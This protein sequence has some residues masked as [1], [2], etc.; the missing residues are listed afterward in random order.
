MAGAEVASAYVTIIPKLDES[1]DSVG[2]KMKAP[3]SKG[4]GDAGKLAGL[5]FNEGMAGVLSKFVVPAAIVATLV[6]VGKMG[7]DAYS[8]VEEGANKVILATGATGEAAEQLK[9]VYKEVA[10]SVVGDFED[11]GEAV[12]E[13]NTRLGLEGDELEAASE[14]AMKF[15]KVNG[16][17]AKDA[18][19]DVTRMMNNAGISADQYEETLDKLTVAAQQSG[20]D[21]STLAQSVNANSASFKE[22]GFSTD[23]AIAMLA[24]FEKSGVNSSTVLAGMK[25]GVAN[26]AKEGK[27]ASEG[28]RD[29]VDGVAD[30]SVTMED[31]IK[32]FGSKAGVE[33][34]NAAQKGQLSFEDMYAAVTEGSAGMT[35]EMYRDTLTATEKMDL[36]WKNITIAGA[37]LFAPLVEAFAGFLTDTVIPFAQGVASSMKYVMDV[38]GEVWGNISGFVETASS[39][40]GDALTGLGSVLNGVKNTF[41]AIERAI[42]DPINTARQAVE[43]AINAIMSIINGAHLELPHFKLPHFNIDGGE[44]PWG[45][46]GMGKAPNI[47]VDWYASG[48][49][50]TKPTVLAGVGEAGPEGVCPLSWLEDKLETGNGGVTVYINDAQV[51]SDSEIRSQVYGILDTLKRKGAM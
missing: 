36:A 15:A 12:G 19:A 43:G 34:Y 44:L 31:A 6:E 37:E 51:N 20:I 9:D 29:F 26:W 49:V 16:V 50:F 14:A 22:M 7:F 45:I 33:M 28:F 10:G 23:E 13:L 46:G 21:V 11:I 5:N 4:S 47:S 17:D 25:K 32:T 40:I 3:L 41:S 24:Q 42:S 35:D 48:A 8:Q 18:V 30:G 38:A 27:S 2:E 1:M 39:A